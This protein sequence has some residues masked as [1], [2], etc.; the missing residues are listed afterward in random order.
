MT[1]RRNNGSLFECLLTI[2]TSRY[3]RYISTL[4]LVRIR[5]QQKGYYTIHVANEDDSKEMTFDLVV[6]G[7][8]VGHLS[9]VS[10]SCI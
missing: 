6:K 9:P 5:L 2:S 3:C 1:Q 7:E 4:T 10:I 8:K